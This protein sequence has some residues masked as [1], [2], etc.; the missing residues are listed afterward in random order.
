M[1]TQIDK[2]PERAE[3]VQQRPAVAPRVD[4]FENKDEILL[5]ADM[6]GVSKDGL[7]INVSDEQL[8]IE[9]R[10]AD[11]PTGRARWITQATE[12]SALANSVRARLPSAREEVETSGAGGASFSWGMGGR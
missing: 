3:A 4:I 2:R 8:S 1:S 12:L 9:G 7:S 11:A 5:V 6:P 10:I